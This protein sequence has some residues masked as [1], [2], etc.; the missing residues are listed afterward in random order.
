MSKR[1]GKLRHLPIS[2][3]KMA[4]LYKDIVIVEVRVF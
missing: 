2:Y 1:D 4:I 3:R